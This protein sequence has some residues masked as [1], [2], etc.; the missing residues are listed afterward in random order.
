MKGNVLIVMEEVVNQLGGIVWEG[1]SHLDKAVIKI[2]EP[3]N[4][5]IVGFDNIVNARQYGIDVLIEEIE[6]DLQKLIELYEEYSS[7]FKDNIDTIALHEMVVDDL[8]DCE[9][10][11]ESEII[12]HIIDSWDELGM[13]EYI[14][15]NGMID[16][17]GLASDIV[18]SVGLKA[19]LGKE[20]KVENCVFYV[21]NM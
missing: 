9:D 13:V 5:Y 17:R 10:L 7:Q 1:E 14:F 18:D 2:V 4:R 3:F 12:D 15:D 8:E 19:I 21:K 16:F 20:I 6:G 11:D